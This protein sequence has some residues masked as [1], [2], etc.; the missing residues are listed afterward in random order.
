MDERY[1][2]IT[3]IRVKDDPLRAHKVWFELVEGT[4]SLDTARFC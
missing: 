1:D 3:D 4:D 2:Y